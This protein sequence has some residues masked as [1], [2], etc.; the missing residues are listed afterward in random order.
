MHYNVIAIN[1]WSAINLPAL[2]TCKCMCAYKNC[3]W[4]AL[5]HFGWLL[6]TITFG[7]SQWQGPRECNFG[8]MWGDGLRISP[9]SLTIF[10]RQILPK[11]EKARIARV[12]HAF[13]AWKN[14]QILEYN[15]CTY[16]PSLV[17]FCPLVRL[18]KPKNKRTFYCEPD[19]S[20][21]F[22]LS[23]ESFVL[24]VSKY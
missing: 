12:K 18:Q 5:H 8:H 4:N 24:T 11:I 17:K 6:S 9:P 7:K 10:G 13:R 2:H 15:S 23:F 21:C 14:P 19:F 1:E 22:I 16:L 3:H 20:Y